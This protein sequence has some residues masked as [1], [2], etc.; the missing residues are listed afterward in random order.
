MM[1]INE[2]LLMRYLQDE[3]TLEE[4][5]IVEAWESQ[6]DDNKKIL[7]QLYFILQASD[8]LQTMNT[9]SP[10][11][12]LLNLKRKINN[13]R[14][15]VRFHKI[16]TMTQ[17]IAAILFIPILIFAGYLILQNY[18]NT[19]CYVEA[20]T[21]S[22]MV[23][24]F[25]LP[26]GSKVWLNSGGKLKYPVEFSSK[27]REVYLE[28]QGYFSVKRNENAPFVVRIDNF[29]SV[30][31]L[32]TEFNV[33]AYED[34]HLIETTLVT[35]KV[36]LNI[37]L[38]DGRFIQKLLKPN[39][40]ATYNRE[41]HRLCIATVNTESDKMWREGKM[42]FH[43]HPM[44]QVLKVLSRYYNVHFEVKNPKIMQS[45]ITAKFT[46]EPLQQVLEYLE[47]ASGI[48]F[49][50]KRPNQIENDTLST[51]IIEVYK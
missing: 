33:T 49:K 4:S 43:R 29:Y 15:S 36:K 41:T 5:A 48:K 47:L 28:G 6:S 27:K 20:K 25:E 10:Q 23:S 39:E 24:S 8:R 42:I 11:S 1:D 7:E 31:V 2:D 13:R 34:D 32:G 46:N 12:A 44:E 45:K 35:G 26:D 16:L 51:S 21:N 18:N 30:E 50:I 19:Q 14:N 9:V 3:C 40:K 17:R 22:G 37:H 38:V